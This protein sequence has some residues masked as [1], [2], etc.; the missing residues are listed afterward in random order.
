MNEEK[1]IPWSEYKKPNEYILPRYVHV[2]VACPICGKAIF[3]D[4]SVVL[5]SNPPK[6]RYVYIH[7]GW[8]GYR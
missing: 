4:E 2:V 8:S 1:L 3:R 6:Y 7:C 5:T